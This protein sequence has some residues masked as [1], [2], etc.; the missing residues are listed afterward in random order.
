MIAADDMEHNQNNNQND[1]ED[2]NEDEDV[3]NIKHSS[4]LTEENLTQIRNNNP[5][6]SAISIENPEHIDWENES[7]SFGA[8]DKLKY[9]YI[10][11]LMS[12]SYDEYSN[13]FPI[14][15]ETKQNIELFCKSIGSNRS[16]ETFGIGESDLATGL[17]NI[18]NGSLS[19]FFEY[20]DNL[21]SIGFFECSIGDGN[22]N[23]LISALSRRRNKSS[24]RSLEMYNCG[25]GYVDAEKLIT[26]LEGY[27]NLVKLSLHDSG[28]ERRESY[29]AL[30]KILQ[31]PRHKL[32]ELNLSW[33]NTNGIKTSSIL[34]NALERN[35]TLVSFG[36]DDGKIPGVISESL[37]QNIT[38]GE[39]TIR[40]INLTASSFDLS[41]FGTFAACLHSPNCS[42]K[43]LCLYNCSLND[44]MATSL[45]HGMSNNTTLR[46][47]ELGRNSDITLP[48]WQS[49]L[50]CL[51]PSALMEKLNINECGIVD[52]VADEIATALAENTTLKQLSMRSNS[53]ITS[54]ALQRFS[55]CLH[56]PNL[57]LEKLDLSGYYNNNVDSETVVAFAN[58]LTLVNNT[59][60]HSLLLINGWGTDD[61]F[62][63]N[64]HTID[65]RT[66][67][68]VS[69]L[70]CNKTDIG[71]IYTSNHT[72]HTLAGC[73]F[74]KSSTPK[75]IA[76]YLK[77]NENDDKV[78]VAR[79]KILQY[80]FM[81]GT[82]N[83]EE[84]VDMEW[85][86]LPQALAWAGRNNT[87]RSLLYKI[88]QSMP[89]LFDTESKAKA[90]GTKR[91]YG[92]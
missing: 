73:G 74:A 53:S 47:L 90:T 64:N 54:V 81:N 50:V 2:Y 41:E 70:L 18:F 26:V 10:S 7:K 55:A 75:D 45:G 69:N 32:K 14:D 67:Q 76:A 34:A 31:D 83:I 1:G 37:A 17:S 16:I 3:W 68:I 22:Y 85:G 33:N 25:I 6:I 38:C 63:L 52:G 30:A 57:V 65:E 88:C 36:I 4:S 9:I 56:N 89:A 12:T 92:C 20:N 24:L 5:S 66:R 27:D 58:A 71:S 28:F 21:R 15:S 19:P 29:T 48:G 79:Q 59:R 91:K 60:L 23:S 72:L 8:N 46:V 80:H 87:G 61:F 42:L 78:E 39:S 49:I 62:N 40:S 13:E 11:Y 43:R 51:R 82:S 86:E 84:F 44:Q 35:R 77:L